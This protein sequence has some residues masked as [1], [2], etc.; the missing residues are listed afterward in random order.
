MQGRGASLNT[1]VVALALVVCKPKVFAASLIPNKDTL[2]L[3]Q[4]KVST[5]NP[6][7]TLCRNIYIPFVGKLYRIA[8]Y[9]VEIPHENHSFLC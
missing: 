3:S 6:K 4:S 2:L 7:S 8:Y 5:K 9:H 1:V